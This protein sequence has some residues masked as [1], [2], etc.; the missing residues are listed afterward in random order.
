MRHYPVRPKAKIGPKAQGGGGVDSGAVCA[1]P[2]D[3]KFG[4]K[5][6]LFGALGGNLTPKQP[7]MR[8]CVKMR[9]ICVD[10]YK[11]A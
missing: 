3:G 9:V 7:K 4:E 10:C 11:S 6:M 2:P 1:P 5:W 8:T